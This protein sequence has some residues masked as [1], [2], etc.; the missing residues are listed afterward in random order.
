MAWSK[1]HITVGMWNERKKTLCS[2][3]GTVENHKQYHYPI[4]IEE[5]WEYNPDDVCVTCYKKWQMLTGKRIVQVIEME[6]SD[7]PLGMTLSRHDPY[8]V[9]TPAG[10]KIGS[11]CNCEDYP[12]CGH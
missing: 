2:I 7:E 12:C 9:Y 11:T 8:G 5:M 6:V 1:S 3:P 10:E 4:D